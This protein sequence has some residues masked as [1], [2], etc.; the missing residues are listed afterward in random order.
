MQPEHAVADAT[1]PLI[2]HT[3]FERRL[4]ARAQT[5]G[6][7]LP[8]QNER[9]RQ[10]PGIDGARAWKVCD[11]AHRGYRLAS[12]RTPRKRS[13]NLCARLAAVRSNSMRRSRPD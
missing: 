6:S 2:Y 13:A 8:T 7:R 1:L 11:S 3:P 4:F 12:S 10:Y 5:N 9:I